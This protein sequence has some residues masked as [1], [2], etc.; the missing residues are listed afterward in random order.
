MTKVTAG[1]VKAALSARFCQPEWA[2][3]FE[4]LNA[5]GAAHTR[6]ADAIA[7]SLWPSRGL[8]LWGMEIKVY[9]SD[10]LKER[11]DP[12][13]A[14]TIAKYCD[15]WWLVT[16]TGVVADQSEVP[17][18]WGWMEFDGKKIVTRRDAAKTE[19]A[20]MD[21]RFLAALLR[22]ADKVDAALVDAE[23]EKRLATM[24]ERQE[25]EIESRVNMRTREAQAIKVEVEAFEAAAGFK[26]G[27]HRGFTSDAAEI[28]RAVAMI[29]RSGVADSWRNLETLADML[30]KQ[31]EQI[32]KTGR[33]MGLIKPVE[34]AA[35]G[36]GNKA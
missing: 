3:L 21:R 2:L 18:A 5:T 19:A 25:A 27:Q 12:T 17:P 8:E 9:R 23:V 11:Q 22:R 16:A 24:K 35:G 13:K 1:Q 30:R 4:V 26:I 36:E 10:W 7:M 14:E 29:Q 20:P 33:D 28:G 15:K 34:T 6:A 31:A 32:E